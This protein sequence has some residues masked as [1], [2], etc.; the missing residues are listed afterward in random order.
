MKVFAASG[1]RFIVLAVARRTLTERHEVIN[2]YA[3]GLVHDI[4]RGAR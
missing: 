2:P 1:V 3:D 4:T